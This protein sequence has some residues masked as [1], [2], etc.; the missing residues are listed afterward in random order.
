[1]KHNYFSLT[2]AC[3]Q[4]NVSNIENV[5]KGDTY[6]RIEIAHN[7]YNKKKVNLNIG[8]IMWQ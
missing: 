5:D 4:Q 6:K 2:P 7:N 8:K 3:I 1:M